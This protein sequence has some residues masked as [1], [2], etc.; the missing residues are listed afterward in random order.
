M[1]IPPLLITCLTI[2]LAAG[3]LVQPVTSVSVP[4]YVAMAEPLTVR[5]DNDTTCVD[6]K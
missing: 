5:T 2:A 6:S 3:A 1:N 4:L